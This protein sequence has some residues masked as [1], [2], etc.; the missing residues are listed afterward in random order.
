MTRL[1]AALLVGLLALACASKVTPVEKVIT[2]LEDLK[3]ETEEE[4]K[5]E[6]ATYDTFTCFCKDKT[7][8][9]SDAI[10]T[11]QDNIEELAATL[12][13]QTSIKNAKIFE[14]Q[15]MD[16]LIAKLDK[17]MAKMTAVREKEKTRYEAQAADLGNAVSSLEG[18]ISN[19]KAAMPASLAQVKSS[20]ANPVRKA[21]L[22]A[23]TL[24]VDPTHSR[25]VA[26]LLQEDP[27]MN[28][29]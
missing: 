25:K 11:D 6:A 9:K 2:L 13:E 28:D 3:T 12:Q 20:V 18:S 10:K 29:G 8:E 21:L 7:E 15:E 17:D 4:G 24:D 14:M 23:D 27:E 5:T 19:L 1:V 22:I 26:A 16:Q